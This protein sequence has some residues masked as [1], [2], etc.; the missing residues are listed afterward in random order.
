LIE[1]SKEDSMGNKDL[2]LMAHLM[3][4]AGFGATRDEL[5][6]NV[7]RGFEAT[8]EV[9]LQ[10]EDAPEL[11]EDIIFRYYADIDRRQQFRPNQA[12]WLYRMTNTKRPLEEKMA[13]FWHHVF[14]TGYGKV[15]HARLCSL[16]IDMLRRHALGDFR[17]LLVEI[18]KDPAMIEWLDNW[19]NHKDTPNENYGREL[20]ELFS[21]GVGNYTEDDVREC[22]RAFTGWTY[23][24][25]IP[26]YPYGRHLFQFEFRADD[27]DD[28]E[29]TFLG[30]TGRFNGE[31]IIDIIVQQP[32]TARFLSRHLYNF[33]VAD[34]AQVPAWNNVP[35]RDPEA[36]QT[37]TEAY[38]ESK[39][40]IRHM[41]R[42]LFLS[43]FFKSEEV[44]FA[45]VKSPAELAASVMHLVGDYT[46]PKPGLVAISDAVTYADQSLMNPPSVEGWHTGTEWITSGSLVQRVNF[47]ATQVGNTELPGV[48]AIIR[49]LSAQGRK[50]SAEEF[51]DGCADLLGPI[52]LSESTR[53]E[54]IAHAQQEGEIRHATKADQQEFTQRVGTML[55]LIAATREYQMT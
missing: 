50:M 37:L 54:L 24:P 47:A 26:R 6:A 33:F 7:A 52:R 5:E 42:T 49:R 27:H 55:Q 21:M 30:Y 44:R 11:D 32:A 29:K 38:F 1:F 9:L 43:D 34:E 10:P 2:E 40:N 51:V 17:T 36:I 15:N 53:Q 23:A 46:F 13:L 22:A 19:S 45:K 14:A 8:V 39:G 31:D 16:Q 18:S 3:R 12:Y 35:P 25:P 20:L 48:R 41:L 28:G 4:R